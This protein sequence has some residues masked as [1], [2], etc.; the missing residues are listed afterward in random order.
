MPATVPQT[1]GPP[2]FPCKE[3]SDIKS[4]DQRR[5]HVNLLML[6]GCSEFERTYREDGWPKQPLEDPLGPPHWGMPRS[7]LSHS[8]TSRDGSPSS[9][10]ATQRISATGASPPISSGAPGNAAEAGPPE[11]TCSP[12]ALGSSK[13]WVCAYEQGGQ[14]AADLARQVG[15]KRTPAGT[16]FNVTQPGHLRSKSAQGVHAPCCCQIK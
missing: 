7:N 8:T 5:R 6:D 2:H 13:K 10:T 14:E 15:S 3:H 1:G 16:F 11:D 12:A 9:M 4:A